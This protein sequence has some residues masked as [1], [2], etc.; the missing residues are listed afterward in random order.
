MLFPDYY[1][2]I[3]VYGA[4]LGVAPAAPHPHPSV[5]PVRP[6]FSKQESFRNF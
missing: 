6:I 4:A 3:F 1:T 5:R 2:A